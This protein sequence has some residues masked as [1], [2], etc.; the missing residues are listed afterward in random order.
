MK[1]KVVYGLLLLAVM[2][3]TGCGD[4]PVVESQATEEVPQSTNEVETSTEDV[5][6]TV[7][8]EEPEESTSS[9]HGLADMDLDV[10]DMPETIEIGVDFDVEYTE[11]GHEEPESYQYPVW[12]EPYT[13][14]F[15]R[16]PLYDGF[17]LLIPKGMEHAYTMDGWDAYFMEDD[18]AFIRARFVANEDG[19]PIDKVL[20]EYEPMVRVNYPDLILTEIPT[21]GESPI[22]L[23]TYKSQAENV[24][25]EYAIVPCKNGYAYVE[26][27][28]TY[29]SGVSF[30]K[31]LDHLK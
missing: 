11:E 3:F 22:Y 18:S 7:K 9:K 21:K 8:T 20:E 24:E 12:Q 6:T 30:E 19:I 14:E 10:P 16:A 25:V 1:K 26:Y 31:I 23:F 27:S 13:L 29:N 28:T 15:D 4:K 5:H 17:E 2:G